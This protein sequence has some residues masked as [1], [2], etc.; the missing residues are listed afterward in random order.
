MTQFVHP[1]YKY[2]RDFDIVGNYR[3]SAVELIH[4]ATNDSYEKCAEFVN[5]K[6]ETDWKPIDPTIQC[7]ARRK[8]HTDRHFK[9]STLL[10]YLNFVQQGGHV[11][12]PSFICYVNPEQEESFTVGFIR[13]NLDNRYKVKKRAKTAELREEKDLA[14]YLNRLQSNFKIRNNSISGA[15]SSAYNS[16][17]YTS[18]HTTLT[19]ITRT[20][21]SYANAT[22]EKFLAS[23]R[24]YHNPEVTLENIAY[25]AS[26]ANLDVILE[27]IKQF[28]LVIPSPEQLEALIFASTSLYWHNDESEEMIRCVI[29]GLSPAQR[30]AVMYMGDLHALHT[31]NDLPMRKFYQ[32]FFQDPRPITDADRQKEIISNASD[33]DISLSML[34][35][36]DFIRGKEPKDL[37]PELYAKWVGY[38]NQINETIARYRFFIDAFLAT[39]V[40]PGDVFSIPTVLRKA[41]LGSDTDSSLFTTEHQVEWFMGSLAESSRAIQISGITSF[42]VSE[43][44]SH[45]L[46]TFSTQIG[47]RQSELHRLSMKAEVYGQG[48]LNTSITKTYAMISNAEEGKYY[49][50]IK[51]IIKGVLLRAAKI[52]TPIRNQIEQFAQYILNMPFK[53]ETNNPLTPASI[54]ASIEHQLYRKLKV[55]NVDYLKTEKIK[56]PDTYGAGELNNH[57]VGV[58]MWNILLADKYGKCD[59][60]PTEAININVDMSKMKEVLDWVDSI[61]P[62][63][64]EAFVQY[65]QSINKTSG[66]NTFFVPVVGITEKGTIP[67]EFFPVMNIRKTMYQLMQPFYILANS[68]YLNIANEKFT[69]FFSDDISM[70]K[71]QQYIP[72]G[73]DI[74]I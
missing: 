29:Q 22:N 42:L 53:G 1:D 67:K 10:S 56:T 41:V 73:Y 32:S 61:D 12:S 65:M 26:R 40:F 21:T 20:I 16:L 71:A 13:L 19:S 34:L 17:Y 18:A 63:R 11:L 33:N 66:L 37:T 44:I 45:T 39:D 27:A 48:M 4:L 51:L 49:K 38:I 35:S 43:V 50:H 57:I 28:D 54:I 64:R 74:S 52:P 47:V 14:N 8:P 7:F 25:I 23:N 2:R 55:G 31:L 69:R 46:A 72:E 24:H 15:H 6:L 59:Q 3:K 60:L 70:E 5:R 68:L 36:V 62:G 9:E 58:R 30:A